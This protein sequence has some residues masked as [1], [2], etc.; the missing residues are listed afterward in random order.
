MNIK[1]IFIL[2]TVSQW[3]A[4]LITVLI[5]IFVPNGGVICK[6]RWAYLGLTVVLACLYVTWV[7]ILRMKTPLVV[8]IVFAV[9]TI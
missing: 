6:Y 2:C 8:N 9:I 1:S 7:V 3:I 5:F 4:M